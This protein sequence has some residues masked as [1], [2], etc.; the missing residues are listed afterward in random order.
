M[1]IYINYKEYTLFDIEFYQAKS[2]IEKDKDCWYSEI[3]C[4]VCVKGITHFLK[5]KLNDLTFNVDEFIKDSETIQ[6][7]RGGLWEQH[8][9]KL[10]DLETNSQRHYHVFKPELDEIINSY[11]EKYGFSINED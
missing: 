11:C 6:E 4:V 3:D 10:C 1:T 8:S 7:I 5:D 2:E 9:N